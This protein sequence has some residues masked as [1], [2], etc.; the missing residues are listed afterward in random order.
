MSPGSAGAPSSG[1]ANKNEDDSETPATHSNR[2][3]AGPSTI[4][5]G[6]RRPPWAVV[7]GQL[8]PRHSRSVC[9]ER[10]KDNLLVW[11]ADV[12]SNQSP[13]T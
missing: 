12:Q 9:G 6:V 11:L 8:E 1:S 13:S 4:K 2:G 10:G 5:A 7:F 3:V